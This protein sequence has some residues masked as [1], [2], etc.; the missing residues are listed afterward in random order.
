MKSRAVMC[1]V[2]RFLLVCLLMPAVLPAAEVRTLMIG[3]TWVSISS[4]G[5]NQAQMQQR[6]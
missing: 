4:Y 5:L 6:P 3:D 2:R 1:Y